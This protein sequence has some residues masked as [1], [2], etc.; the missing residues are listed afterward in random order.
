MKVCVCLMVWLLI[1]MEFGNSSC[2]LLQD[3]QIF[4]D[5]VCLLDG[6]AMN[7]NGFDP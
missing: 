2:A 1:V 3:A 4:C 7:R 5:N 6:V